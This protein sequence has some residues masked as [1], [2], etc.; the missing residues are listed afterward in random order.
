MDT[1]SANLSAKLSESANVDAHCRSVGAVPQRAAVELSLVE[2]LALLVGIVEIPLQIDK[3]FMY[4]QDD[5]SL[6]AVGGFNLSFTTLALIY[7]YAR[8][9][10]DMALHRRRTILPPL[11]GIPMVFYL[12]TV[13]LSSLSASVTM[14]T[15]FDFANLMHGYLLF[16]YIAN[17]VQ[18]HKDVLFMLLA[19]AT[20]L[21]VQAMLIF[22]ASIIGMDDEQRAF[23]PL[24]LTVDKGRRH[25]GSMHSPVL[26]G[27]TMALIW[28]PVASALT[29]VRQRWCWSYLVVATGAGMLAI[30]LTQTRGALL[31]SAIGSVILGAGLL[32]RG[33]LPKWTLPMAMLLGVMSIYPMFLIYKKRIEHGDGDSAIARKHLSLIALETIAERPILGH[34][35]GNCHIAA[36][37][38]ANQGEYRS[39]WYFTIHSK[40]LLVWIETGLIGLIAFLGVLGTG[41]YHGLACWRSRD[42]ALSVLGLALFAALAGHSVHMMVDVF[43]SRTQVQML[44]CMLGLAAAVYK[45]SRHGTNSSANPKTVSRR[46]TRSRFA[47]NRFEIAGGVA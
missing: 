17:R 21:L 26:A 1:P 44:W 8:W 12:G 42:P 31:T 40:Y 13:L 36:Q 24:L 3:Y 2:R 35:S 38:I 7:L 46:A 19:L 33:W 20:T 34:G 9:F 11:F 29:F 18:T 23:G 43:N 14:L 32:A 10:A 28:L 37:D 41:F 16:F 4:H 15:Y 25:G 5:A 27:S 47:T 30:L 45:L 6:G 39:E 22:F